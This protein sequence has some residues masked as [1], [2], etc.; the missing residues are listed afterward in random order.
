MSQ[1]TPTVMKAAVFD[2][3]GH[4]ELREV[5]V[6][7]ISGDEVLVR[8]EAVGV[9]G[10][11]FHIHAGFVPAVTFPIIAGH[12]AVG[13]IEGV[14]PDA[15]GSLLGKRV[16]VEGKA[17]TGFTRD[18]AYANYLTVPQSQATPLPENMG[19]VVGCLV[20]PLACAIHAVHRAA[21]A[22]GAAV[23]V[24]GQGSSGLCVT[25]ALKQL[26]GARIAVADLNPERL[27]LGA[28]FG[29]DLTLN[30]TKDDVPAR[31][32]QW[33]NGELADI[34]I[35]VTGAAGGAQLALSLAKFGG[36]VVVYG[37]F[38]G[39]IPLDFST[40]TL[41]EL[42]VLGTVGSPGTYPAALELAASG[43]VDLLPIASKFITLEGVPALFEPGSGGSSER[44]TVVTFE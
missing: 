12:E 6:P 32:R 31:I 37:V 44:K 34:V 16:V 15:D 7:G 26:T 9:C 42:E 4:V 43:K 27:A 40:V 39:P 22:N 28:A 35:E 3:P 29:A 21:P 13:I 20:D 25:A 41:N 11:D 10:T 30:P 33:N 5:P 38:D 1:E 14:G 17:G 8:M 18:G 24:V 36:R 19:P 23:V 2:R